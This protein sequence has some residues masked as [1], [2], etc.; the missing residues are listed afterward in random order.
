MKY[1]QIEINLLPPEL[2]PGPAVRY[3]VLFN[4][5][6]VAI[7]V[8]FILLDA[9]TG[10]PHLMLLKKDI[11]DRKQLVAQRAQ[12]VADYDRLIAVRDA[13]GS[14]GRLI[15]LASGAYVDLPVIMDRL[16]RVIPDGVY[17]D[18]VEH[19]RPKAGSRESE[20]V[21]GLKATRRDPRMLQQTLAAFKQE[22]L[23][24][25]CYMRS[26][27]YQ[28]EALDEFM[29]RI[30]VLWKASGTGIDQG[31]TADQFGFEIHIMLERPLPVRGV[32]VAYDVSQFFSPYWVAQPEKTEKPAK[33]GKEQTVEAGAQAAKKGTT[34]PAGAAAKEAQ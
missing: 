17:L 19:R 15:S 3:A 6:V 34:A 8:A 2:Q 5:A 12:E 25:N 29:Q 14:Y 30:N 16:A 20:I 7:V 21:V 28:A 27:E 31:T 4:F 26:A 1:A 13:I 18:K 11:R 33:T 10:L 22:P 24:A 23:L 9:A 32:P